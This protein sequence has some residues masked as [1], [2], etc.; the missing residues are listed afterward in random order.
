MFHVSKSP[1][2]KFVVE[3]L[4][5]GPQCRAVKGLPVLLDD[6]LKLLPE[7]WKGGYGLVLDDR[8][9]DEALLLIGLSSGS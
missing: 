1:F 7:G 2:L 4:R 9:V 6:G 3:K 5:V 8:D